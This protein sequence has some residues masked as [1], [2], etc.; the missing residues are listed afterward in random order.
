MWSITTKSSTR[1]SIQAGFYKQRVRAFHNKMEE[2]YNHQLF[3]LI[4]ARAMAILFNQKAASSLSVLSISIALGFATF[5]VFKRF[6][7]TCA[8]FAS[9]RLLV[10]RIYAIPIL[11]KRFLSQP[12]KRWNHNNQLNGEQ[13]DSDALV[14]WHFYESNERAKYWYTFA[15]NNKYA[16][17]PSDGVFSTDGSVC[18]RE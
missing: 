10:S 18:E 5:H 12:N 13:F 7:F 11:C 9:F 6:C 8:F 2:N 14:R 1:T 3:T 4:I 15:C 17:V 16:H